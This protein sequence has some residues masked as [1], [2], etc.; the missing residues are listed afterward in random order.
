MS[1]RTKRLVGPVAQGTV[2]ATLYTTPSGRT[3]IL[4]QLTVFS[5]TGVA[6]IVRFF[7][8]GSAV[9]NHVLDLAT[10]NAAVTA[11]LSGLFLVLEPGDTLRAETSTG[12]AT[13][14][15]SGSELDGVAP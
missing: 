15:V 2:N 6:L 9:G 4:K 7:V 10:T 1:V 14:T 5:Q 12:T 3:A 8:N 11:Q 13:I